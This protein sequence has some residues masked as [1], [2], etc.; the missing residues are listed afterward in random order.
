M[1]IREK[2]IQLAES[3]LFQEDILQISEEITQV[4]EDKITELYN[5]E[6]GNIDGICLAAFGS[7]GRKVMA[8]SSDIDF[9]VLVSSND[10]SE[11][12][13]PRIS[14]FIARVWD[15]VANAEFSVRTPEETMKIA[16]E[17]VKVLSYLSDIRFVAGDIRVFNRLIYILEQEKEQL[18]IDFFSKIV[19]DRKKMI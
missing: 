16:L 6:L 18:K 10:I 2:I 9:I 11:K 15:I 12:F 19:Q 1:K 17:D 13:G 5:Q 14:S 4:Y 3:K 7:F 8:P